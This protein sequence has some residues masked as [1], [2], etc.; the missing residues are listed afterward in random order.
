VSVKVVVKLVLNA[1]LI[2]ERAVKT[3]EKETPMSECSLYP[4]ICH[5][6]R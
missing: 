6:G 1:N 2:E 4:H 5:I 3:W